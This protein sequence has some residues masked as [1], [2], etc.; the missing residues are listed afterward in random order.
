MRLPPSPLFITADRSAAMR[1]EPAGELI[2]PAAERVDRRD[3]AV[4]QQVAQ[5][6]DAPGIGAASTS[7]P[8]RKNH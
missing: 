8:H 2:G 7:T 1:G 3:V 4:G 6:N 5:R